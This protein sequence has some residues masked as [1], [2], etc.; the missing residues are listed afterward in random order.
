MALMRSAIG[1]EIVCLSCP[2]IWPLRMQGQT[3]QCCGAVTARSITCL[4]LQEKGLTNLPTATPRKSILTN[5]VHRF[6]N[7]I[8]AAIG[9]PLTCQSNFLPDA[10]QSGEL[11]RCFLA[12]ALPIEHADFQPCVFW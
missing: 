2:P 6:P 3:A 4:E 9:G 1:S 7:D 11:E 8:L 12:E 10:I 5:L